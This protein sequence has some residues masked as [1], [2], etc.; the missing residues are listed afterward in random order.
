MFTQ[1]YNVSTV[2][3]LSTREQE[4]VHSKIWAACTCAMDDRYPDIFTPEAKQ[5]VQDILTFDYVSPYRQTSKGQV[6]YIDIWYADTIKEIEV[7]TDIELASLTYAN[8]M[9]NA[10]AVLDINDDIKEKFVDLHDVDVP[11]QSK[12]WSVTIDGNGTTTGVTTTAKDL[13]PRWIDTELGQFIDK[14]K[15]D[16]S[17]DAEFFHRKGQNGVII[18]PWC[19]YSSRAYVFPALTGTEK[20][21]SFDWKK[22][23]PSTAETRNRWIDVVTDVYQMI[24]ADDAEWI[25]SLIDHE[26]QQIDFSF[27]FDD[28]KNLVDVY[29][30][31]REVCEFK[32]ARP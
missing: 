20:M 8:E 29:V 27:I 24:T 10:V 4:F 11:T 31:K 15:K 13:D 14:L 16:A 21:T 6:K 25:R 23:T 30:Y 22:R 19:P 32:V 26:D 2:Y 9:L 12:I 18:R 1:E 28:D 5:K 3:R 7:T 17:R